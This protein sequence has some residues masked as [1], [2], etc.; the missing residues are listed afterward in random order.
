MILTRPARSGRQVELEVR[1]PAAGDGHALER[2]IRE[3]GTT[4]VR[5]HEHSGRIE[6]AP[7]RRSAHVRQFVAQARRKV[8]G[9]A[10]GPDLVP[11]PCENGARGLDRERVVDPSRQFVDRRQV[12]QLHLFLRVDDSAALLASLSGRRSACVAGVRQGGARHR[13]A[14]AD[15]A[16]ALLRGPVLRVAPRPR[17]CARGTRARGRPRPRGRR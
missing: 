9:L 1:V 6:H 10:A 12:S 3:W 11:C 8:A 17:A 4:Q 13:R 7:K 15:P 14:G 16:R 2:L 5:V